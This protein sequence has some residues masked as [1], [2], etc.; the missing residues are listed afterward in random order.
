MVLLI[1]HQVNSTRGTQ[2]VSSSEGVLLRVDTNEHRRELTASECGIM[3]FNASLASNMH[4]SVFSSNWWKLWRH[5]PECTQSYHSGQGDHAHEPLNLEA[6]LEVG[7]GEVFE[8]LGGS[9]RV[10]CHEHIDAGIET[11]NRECLGKHENTWHAEREPQLNLRVQVENS[12]AV[13]MSSSSHSELQYI[14]GLESHQ[15]ISKPTPISF[16]LGSDIDARHDGM[17]ENVFMMRSK[18]PSRI[19]DIKGVPIPGMAQL[20]TVEAIAAFHL[21]PH[22]IQRRIDELCTLDVVSLRPTAVRTVSRERSPWFL[23]R[24]P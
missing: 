6:I 10:C 4:S 13:R 19:F 22:R 5:R 1:R 3:S 16:H 8:Q 18:Y 9:Q 11:V 7:G 24:G 14:L 15:M 2:G 20:E 12:S 23:A 21:L 17:I